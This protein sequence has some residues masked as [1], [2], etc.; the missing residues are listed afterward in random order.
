MF[1][2]LN[3]SGDAVTGAYIYRDTFYYY[4][5]IEEQYTELL[6]FEIDVLDV[7]DKIKKA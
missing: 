7:F 6:H 4:E 2:I 3:D 1:E 5:T